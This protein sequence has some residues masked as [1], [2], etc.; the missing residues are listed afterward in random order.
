MSGVV[1]ASDAN[2]IFG[3]LNRASEVPGLAP[4]KPKHPAPTDH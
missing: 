4:T 1:T 2:R 3:N